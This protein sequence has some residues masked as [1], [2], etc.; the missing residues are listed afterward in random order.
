MSKV[1]NLII[2][3]STLEDDD[4]I[5]QSLKSFNYN[6]QPFEIASVKDKNLPESWYG[7]NRKL[8]CNVLIGA[9]NYIDLNELIEFMKKAITWEAPEYV[10]IIVKEH[11]DFKF[12]L[13]DVF[14]SVSSNI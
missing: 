2:T 13:I 11:N 10:Q 3:F 7:G 5:I 12:R 6:G 8:E 1:T 9:Y 4:V 14:S